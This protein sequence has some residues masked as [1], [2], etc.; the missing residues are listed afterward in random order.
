MKKIFSLLFIFLFSFVIV[1]CSDTSATTTSEVKTTT[2]KSRDVTLPTELPTYTEDSV[3]IHYKRSDES[4]KRWSLW[5]WAPQADGKKYDFN[6]MD[7]FGV[8]AYY[9][10][11][12]IQD[13][14]PSELGFIV[15]DD[16]GGSWN[17]KDVDQDRFID[18]S[19]FDKDQNNVYHVYLFNGDAN[20]YSTSDKKIVDK[21][22]LSQFTSR[23]EIKVTTSNPIS[24]YRLYKNGEVNKT[25]EVSNV[26]SLNIAISQGDFSFEDQY[27]IEVTFTDS[28]ANLKKAINV[29]KLFDEL[30]DQEYYYD[31]ELGAIYSQSETTFK[32]WSPVSKKIVLKVYNSGTPKS[33]SV[34]LG[35]DT[36]VKEVELTKGNKGVFS[37]TVSGDLEGKYYTYTVYNSSNPNGAEIVDP[38][39]KSAGINGLRGMIVDFS[40]TNPEGWD[41]VSVK[42]YKSTELVVYETHV[43]DVT[44]SSTWGGTKANAKKYLGL[45]EEGTTYTKDGVTVTT[46]FDHIKE[47]GVNA[48]QLQP[49]FDQANDEVN[50]SFNWG[51]NPLNY[52]VLE[53]SYSSNAYDGYA[54]IKEFKEVVKAYLNSNINFIMDVVYNHTNSVSGT[55]FDVLMP[56]YY[57]R[58]D[59]NGNLYNGSGC[60]NET[61]SEHLMFRKFMI[62]STTFWLSEYKLAGF[63]FDLM[64]LHDINTMNKIVEE[65]KKVNSNVVIY[66]EPW[67][68]GTSGLSS[69]DAATQSNIDKYVGYGAFNDKLRDELVKGG[70]SDKSSLSW[71]SNDVSGLTTNYDSLIGGI[72]GKT[73]VTNN[74]IGGPE[75]T[76]NY[77][78]CHDNYTLFDRFQAAGIKDQ[79]TVKKMAMLANSIVLTSRGTSFILAGEEFLRTKQGNSNSYNASYA[80][81]EL[82]YALKV[83]NKDMFNNYQ[84]LINLKKTY[85]GLTNENALEYEVTQLD[86]RSTLKYTISENDGEYIF[87]HTNGITPDE[88]TSISLNGY[89]VVFSS[90][91][92]LE[93]FDNLEEFTMEKFETVILKKI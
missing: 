8:I 42:P 52:N 23:T 47:L 44:S 88:R 5:I 55:N 35:D 11:T 76:I 26:K 12:D 10:L 21:I 22:S 54:R 15:A 27:E 73:V 24:S 67:T 90:I 29:N 51:Y 78:T 16:P 87:I 84:F 9:K 30:F 59:S 57:F 83:T 82:N 56:G 63:R 62:D 43:V 77:A 18:F 32:V 38:Y 49:I 72:Q 1:S 17:Q 6:Y 4:Y 58:Y 80:V 60:G 46:G 79:E 3:M 92:S 36:V 39:A 48:V 93:A 68:G 20:I 85:S 71:I 81:N 25:E 28:K 64:G 70:M 91:R 45:S 40:K 89:E 66:G 19:S 33:L 65:C 74:L 37:A 14:I 31:G 34:D 41:D 86:K 53:G 7:D 69:T 2:K 75:K 13:P 61:A 50:P